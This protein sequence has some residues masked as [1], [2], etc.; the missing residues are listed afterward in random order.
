M[1]LFYFGGNEVIKDFLGSETPGVS[2]F[3]S[4]LRLFLQA[5]P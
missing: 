4:I 5:S 3:L 1:K 2:G